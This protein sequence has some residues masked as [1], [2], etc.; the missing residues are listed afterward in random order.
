MINNF[1]KEF[2]AD[3]RVKLYPN[4]SNVLCVVDWSAFGVGWTPGRVTR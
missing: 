1:K 2:N 3:Y 4:K